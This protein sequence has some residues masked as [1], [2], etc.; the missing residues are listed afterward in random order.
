MEMGIREAIDNLYIIATNEDS[1]KAR[2]IEGYYEKCFDRVVQE[3][4]TLQMSI[5]KLICY[6]AE[7]ENKDY[8][9]IRKEFDI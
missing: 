5:N 4:D 3:L 8:E 1:K 6:I 2:D 9:D 7:K